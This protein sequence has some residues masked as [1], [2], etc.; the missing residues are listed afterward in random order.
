MASDMC[1]S[2]QCILCAQNR[3]LEGINA[4]I[5]AFLSISTASKPD[6]T[7]DMTTAIGAIKLRQRVSVLR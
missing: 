4:T 7:P 3:I 6:H 2:L 1:E 5:Y